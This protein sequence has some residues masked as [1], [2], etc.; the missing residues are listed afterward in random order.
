MLEAL[1]DAD[2]IQRFINRPK[3]SRR[4]ATCYDQTDDRYLGFAALSSIWPMD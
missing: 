4:V 2:G 1:A 3:D